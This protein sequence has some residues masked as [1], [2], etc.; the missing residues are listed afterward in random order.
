MI[1]AE[2]SGLRN[3]VSLAA[4]LAA[5][6]GFL[7]LLTRAWKSERPSADDARYR[8][9][10][11]PSDEQRDRRWRQGLAITMIA[12][13]LQCLFFASLLVVAVVKAI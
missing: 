5:A 3:V 12:V 1:L 11:R 8:L 13:L 7:F 6:G 10:G 2:D 9:F 4:L